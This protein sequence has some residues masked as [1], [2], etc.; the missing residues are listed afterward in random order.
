[1]RRL[2]FLEGREPV[3]L[4]GELLADAASGAP[5]RVQLRAAFRVKGDPET[6]AEVDLLAQVKAV[7]EAVAAV[8]P[9]RE[10]LPDERKTRGVARA[11]EAAGLR[12]RGQAAE[13]EAPEEPE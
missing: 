1:R 9:P 7:G 3:K 6:R 4:E 11:L 5:L 8:S 2:A 10:V 12:K 13:E